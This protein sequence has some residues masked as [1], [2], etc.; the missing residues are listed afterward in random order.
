MSICTTGGTST[1]EEEIGGRT[2]GESGG[3]FG[4]GHGCGQRYHLQHSE[5]STALYTGKEWDVAPLSLT[6]WAV[7]KIIQLG[8]S[9]RPY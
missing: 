1:E 2:G 3:P 9:I 5:G 6:I 8:T 4:S 7:P